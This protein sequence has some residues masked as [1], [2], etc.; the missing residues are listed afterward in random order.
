MSAPATLGH[1][2]LREPLGEGG[3]GTVYRAHDPRLGRDVAVKLLRAEQ[4]DEASRERFRREARAASALC[5]PNIVTVFD[6]GEAPNGWFMAMELVQGESL[7][8]WRLDPPGIARLADAGAQ[9]ALALAAAHE[10]GIVHRDVKPE[11]VM[12]RSDGYVKLLDFGLARLMD[13]ERASTMAERRSATGLTSPGLVIGTVRYLSPEQA[14][15]DPIGPPSDVFSLGTMLYELATGSHPF[16]AKTEVG[17]I[18]QIITR[19][20]ALPSDIA[21]GLPPQFDALLRAMLAKDPADRPSALEVADRLQGLTRARSPMDGVTQRGPGAVAN[22]GPSGA[23]RSVLSGVRPGATRLGARRSGVVVG[24]AVELATLLAQWQHVRDGAGRFVGI[25]GEAGIGKSTFVESAL[26]SL[27]DDGPMLVARGRCSERLAGTEAYLPVLDAL[28]GAASADASGRFAALIAEVAPAWYALLTQGDQVALGTQERLKRE[29]VAL[30]RRVTDTRPLVL[31][32]DDMHWA[33]ASTVDLLAYIGAH[34]DG[35]PLLLLAT[36]RAAELRVTGH[37][38]LQLARDLQARDRFHEIAVSLLR[39]DDVAQYLDRTFAGHA[40]PP[41]LAA[42]L[43]ARTEGN[44]LF[45]VDVLRWMS[46]EG[47][48]AESDGRWR[49]QGALDALEGGLPGTVRAMIERK[50]AQLDDT[51][52]RLLQVAAVQG[53]AFDSAALALALRADEADLE[54]RLLLLERVYAFVRRQG[55]ERYPDRSV[56]TRYRFVHVLYQNVLAEEVTASRRASWSRALADGIEARA[57]TQVAEQAAELAL[58]REGARDA[59]AAALWYGVAASRALSR[60]AFVESAALAAR[61]MSQLERVEAGSTREKLELTLRLVLGSVSLVRQGYQA[62][63]TG[64]HMERARVLCDTVG[65]TPAL[66]PALYALVLRA[67]AHGTW[68]EAAAMLEQMGQAGTGEYRALAQATMT[69]CRIGCHAHRGDPQTAARCAHEVDTLLAEGRL[70][71]PPGMHP[72]PVLANLCE[73]VRAYWMVDEVDEAWTQLA[74]ATRYAR[75]RNDPQSEPFLTIF[76]CELHLVLGDPAQAL[77]AAQ[78]GLAIATEHGIAS[79][80]LWNAMYAG[81]AL[82][83]LGKPEEALALMRPT[84][85][86]IEAVGLWVCILQ[87]CSYMADALRQQGDLAAAAAE[88]ER[89][90]VIADRRGF[91]DFV[92]LV[93]IE[94]AKLLAHPAWSGE[95]VL[96]VRDPR[97]ALARA[98]AYAESHGAPGF[99]RLI[100]AAERALG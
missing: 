37:P 9:C 96:G 94:A 60:Y 65:D 61:G 16:M 72:D 22:V 34:L 73:A 18:G 10:A 17:I 44:A 43:H 78:R 46:A 54:D 2:T 36:Y 49:V 7:A 5:H 32:I 75:A 95:A 11:N 50:I 31:Y 97:E 98:T 85:A 25:S 71:M 21:T 82:A 69:L 83:A 27:D 30:L 56:S 91:F 57:K 67:V 81:G 93:W 52:R 28:D 4:V 15:G 92:P 45:L 48:I 63:E 23:F 87:W 6:V 55:E 42:R 58:L 14:S 90:V 1:F 79:E 47:L 8:A 19:E 99:H 70:V 41:D 13:A 62:P 24:H 80:Q 35:L 40:F 51:D 33:D 59:E 86:V 26:A 12:V 38:F 64:E 76:E 29:M 77:A 84:L 3:M 89:A 20:P 100:G 39:L 88:L 74:K 66:L 68:A 53:A